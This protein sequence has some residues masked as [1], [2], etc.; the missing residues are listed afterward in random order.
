MSVV[1]TERLSDK[2]KEISAKLP[3]TKVLERKLETMVKLEPQMEKTLAKVKKAT[4]IPSIAELQAKTE[5]IKVASKG[6]E[7]ATN[8]AKEAAAE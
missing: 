5:A 7:K 1:Q 8:G 6:I 3:E 2:L 4:E